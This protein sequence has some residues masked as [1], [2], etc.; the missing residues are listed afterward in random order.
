MYYP[1]NFDFSI[2]TDDVMLDKVKAHFGVKLYTPQSAGNMFKVDNTSAKNVKYVLFKV[3]D[4]TTI[5]MSMHDIVQ[6]TRTYT[7]TPFV[8]VLEHKGQLYYAYD[9][10]HLQPHYNQEFTAWYIDAENMDGFLVNTKAIC[11]ELS[12]INNKEAGFKL[13]GPANPIR[14]YVKIENKK[15]ARKQLHGPVFWKA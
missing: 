14:T 8:P 10:N 1:N 6:K 2:H 5:E 9:E 3:N 13:I 11:L 4:S 7:G 15:L 12:T